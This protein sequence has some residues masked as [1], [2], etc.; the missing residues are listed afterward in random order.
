MNEHRKIQARAAYLSALPE[1]DPERVLANEHARTCPECA[2]ALAEGAR[3]LALIDGL[4]APAAPTEQALQR[5]SEPI[6]Q[7]L[8]AARALRTRWPGSRIG[9][10]L[11]SSVVSAW[12]IAVA[13]TKHPARDRMSRFWSVA[14]LSASV[15]GIAGILQ[16]DAAAAA[17][18]VALSGIFSAVVGSGGDLAPSAGLHCILAELFAAA[19]PLATTAFLVKTGR[20]ANQVGRFVA[21]AAFGALSGHAALH[22]SCPVRT[23]SPHLWVFHTGGVLLAALVGLAISRIPQLRP[24]P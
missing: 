19:L 12:I 15:L 22:L 4:P 9:L 3:I 1:G 10:A 20:A 11:A 24:A 18:A 5:A 23:A 2:K 7:E 16:F 13:L 14:V 17:T 6:R 21:A 8:E